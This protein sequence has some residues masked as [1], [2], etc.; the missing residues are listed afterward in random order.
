MFVIGLIVGI[1]IG[2]VVALPIMYHVGLKMYNMTADEAS[3][4]YG[5]VYDASWNRESKLF[6]VRDSDNGDCDNLVI[7]EKR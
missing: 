7:L 6:L 5:M 3:E 1:V 4:V 2:L